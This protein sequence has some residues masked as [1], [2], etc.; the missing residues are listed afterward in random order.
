MECEREGQGE[1][2]SDLK[3]DGPRCERSRQAGGIQVPAKKRSCEVCSAEE[4]EAGRQDAA[5]N[6]VGHGQDPRDLGFIDGKMRACRAVPALSSEDIVGGLG[7]SFSVV[8][9]L[10]SQ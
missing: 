10:Y 9:G 4:V 3:D 8:T 5:G 2:R 1:F 7:V 6:S